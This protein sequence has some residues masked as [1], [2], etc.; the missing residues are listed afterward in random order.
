MARA[1]IA[2]DAQLSNLQEAVAKL[3]FIV[4]VGRPQ[5]H[6]SV[7]L[8]SRACRASKRDLAQDRKATVTHATGGHNALQE[9]LELEL[10]L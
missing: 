4:L 7:G 2:D 6:G 5:R 3:S 8:C 1:H 9:K 10:P